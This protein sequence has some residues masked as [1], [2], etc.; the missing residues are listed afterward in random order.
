[1]FEAAARDIHTGKDAHKGVDAAVVEAVWTRLLPGTE[2]GIL[3][4]DCCSR[5]LSFE[6]ELNKN[7]TFLRLKSVIF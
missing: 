3:L 1:M 6:V 7:H 4:V 5:L 2:T